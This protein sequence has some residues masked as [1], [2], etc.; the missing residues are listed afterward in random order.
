M[1]ARLSILP[2]PEPSLTPLLFRFSDGKRDPF[3]AD[4]LV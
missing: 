1:P 2:R 3:L 4:L